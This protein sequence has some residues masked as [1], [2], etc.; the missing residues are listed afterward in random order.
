MEYE[1]WA[2]AE[3][4]A[5]RCEENAATAYENGNMLSHDIWTKR[6]DEYRREARKVRRQHDRAYRA[7]EEKHT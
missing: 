1:R 3:R 6:A 4:N 5:V 2:S 7:E